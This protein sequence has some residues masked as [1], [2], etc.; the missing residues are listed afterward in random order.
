[1]KWKWAAGWATRAASRH[2]VH[3]ILYRGWSLVAVV[4]CV[5]A[6]A[7]GVVAQEELPQIMPGERKVPRKKDAGPRALGLLRLT[8]DGKASLVPIAILINDKFWDATAYKAAPIP[9]ALEPGTV[10]EAEQEGS[11]FIFDGITPNFRVICTIAVPEVRH[12]CYAGEKPW[13]LKVRHRG[14]NSW[15]LCL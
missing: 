8:A 4:A 15:P 5:V 14:G 7:A 1:M 13:D 3:K 12:R 2:A 10:Y 11:S 9:M 6:L